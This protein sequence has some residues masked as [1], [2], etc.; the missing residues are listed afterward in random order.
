MAWIINEAWIVVVLIPLFVLLYS[1]KILRE[2][3]RGVVF[4]LGR[5]WR[6]KGPGLIIII[7]IIEWIFFRSKIFASA[8]FGRGDMI[9][10]FRDMD[11]EHFFDEERMKVQ[12]DVVSLLAHIDVGQFLASP[13]VWA[14]VVVCGLLSAAAI[15]VRRYRD[16]S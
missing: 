10:L 13:S 9:P 1:L 11:F 16:E 7:P 6:V 4:L 3:E 8:V 14:G 5:F 15:Y 2:Y 12:H